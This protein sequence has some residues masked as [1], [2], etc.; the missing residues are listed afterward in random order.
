MALRPCSPL[1]G[2]LTVIT[3]EAE[4][5]ADG[6]SVS[7]RAVLGS[8]VLGIVLLGGTLAE[9]PRPARRYTSCLHWNPLA[10]MKR[11]ETDTCALWLSDD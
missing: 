4:F 7:S 9:C 1:A 11:V 5:E 2:L 3:W 8:D 6:L 10:K